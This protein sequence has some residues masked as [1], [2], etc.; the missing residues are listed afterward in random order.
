[1]LHDYKACRL[2]P[3]KEWLNTKAK[4]EYNTGK[5]VQQLAKT[6]IATKQEFVVKLETEYVVIIMRVDGE[7]RTILCPREIFLE[8][9]LGDTI[10]STNQ[11]KLESIGLENTNISR[12]GEGKISP[13]IYGLITMNNTTTTIWNK[14]IG[15]IT[16]KRDLRC[17]LKFSFLCFL[18]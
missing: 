2:D 6:H 18:A 4:V 17:P 14:V 1:M 7:F 5:Y 13:H 10:M 3:Y 9:K 16:Q 11:T 8:T 15:V 12:F